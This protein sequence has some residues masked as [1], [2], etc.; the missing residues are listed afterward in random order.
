M[1]WELS[2]ASIRLLRGVGAEL[3]TIYVVDPKAASGLLP[4][5]VH[6]YQLWGHF[7]Y[8]MKAHM[9]QGLVLSQCF[10]MSLLLDDAY[11]VD[12]MARTP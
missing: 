1:H 12:N 10:A 4:A 2:L 3:R 8:Q 9:G 7:P 6:Q 5:E 11:Q